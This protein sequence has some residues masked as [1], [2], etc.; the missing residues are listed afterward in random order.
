MP[1]MFGLE[2]GTAVSWNRG[3][4]MKHACGGGGEATAVRLLPAEQHRHLVCSLP[5]QQR[6]TQLFFTTA[7][8]I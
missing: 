4:Q 7:I 8:V 2:A 5:V 6:S 3:R 1:D